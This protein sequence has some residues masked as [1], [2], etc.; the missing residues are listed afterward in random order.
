M[1][2]SF[3]RNGKSRLFPLQILETNNIDLNNYPDHPSFDDII[4]ITTS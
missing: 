4:D 3:S 1:Q 2:Y